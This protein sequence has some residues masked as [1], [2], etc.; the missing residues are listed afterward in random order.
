MC[1]GT[2][3][4]HHF[5]V[6]SSPGSLWEPG[7]GVYQALCTRCTTL[8]HHPSTMYHTTTTTTLVP[9]SYRSLVPGSHRS[10]VP[11]CTRL[12][13]RAW[14][15]C[16]SLVP[17]SHR[18]PD[19]HCM[20]TLYSH[21]SL[22][23]HGRERGGEIF[24]PST[25]TSHSCLKYLASRQLSTHSASARWP[26]IR[27]AAGKSSLIIEKNWSHSNSGMSP[28]P[29]GKNDVHMTDIGLH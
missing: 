13:Q 15:T 2:T 6:A 29:L 16:E 19:T 5:K 1:V 8:V 11:G 4:K 22:P 3:V 24:S 26:V 18:E 27:N 28:R 12:S 20:R 7:D 21:C 23:Y 14:Y 17:G 25:S 10:L 9:G